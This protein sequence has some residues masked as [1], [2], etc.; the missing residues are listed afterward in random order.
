M[1]LYEATGAGALLL[2]D[3]GT[4][5]PELFEPGREVVVYSDAEDLVDTAR[6]NSIASPS[7]L[8][9]RR[10]ATRGPCAHTYEKRIA[11]PAGMLEARLSGR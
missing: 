6:H 7:V 11:E 10:P 3:D 4:N 9:L 8:R 1:R 2:T 5:L